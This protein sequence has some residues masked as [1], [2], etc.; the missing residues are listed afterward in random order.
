MYA[1]EFKKKLW[2][3]ILV[4]TIARL[5]IAGCLE[6]GNDEVYYQTYALHL[7]WNYF[8]HPPM[9]A[10]L[11]RATTLNGLLHRELFIRLGAV[12][13]AAADTLLVFSI[14]KKIGNERSG[15]FAACLF[16]FSFYSSVI[17]GAFILPDAPMLLFW[18]LSIRLMI[19]VVEGKVSGVY[20]ILLGLSIGCCIMSK[21]HGVFLWIGFG[22]YILSERRALLKS[23]WLYISLLVS[24]IVI[25]PI[26]YWNFANHFITYTYHKSRIG[27]FGKKLDFT[28]LLQ[29]VLGS[30][31]YNNPV[32][33]IFYLLMG[34]SL[35][36]GKIVFPPL[37]KIFLWLSLPL[38][39]VILVMSFFNETLPHWSGP[40]Y[41]SLLLLAGVYL[42]KITR[43]ASS[44]SLLKVSGT[45]FLF[46][47]VMGILAIN[48]M[49]V[50][51][52]SA[53]EK[54]LG[55]GDITLDM[56][57]WEGFSR[58]FDSLYLA[59]MRSGAI[60]PGATILSDYW[61]P[62]AHL[63][64]YLAQPYNLNILAIGPLQDI[65]HYAWMNGYRKQIKSGEDAYFIYP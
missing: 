59:D 46:V 25:S 17:A 33:F 44:P 54:N 58:R 48:F 64:H 9:I 38:I 14:V 1:V 8:D 42:D 19:S 16:T 37:Y 39:L 50:S 15:W 21:I 56:T 29:Q 57:G 2:L 6:L 49:P 7:Q 4:S 5:L 63:D 51:I 31:F 45:V 11:I 60:K 27:F 34:V 18:L 30:V 10:L 24:L 35:Y 32:N 28:S 22:G 40:A 23:P 62:A 61:F 12:L 26:F 13:C 41:T 53:D 3:L 52:G 65:H 55:K 20:W 47:V 43:P 36:V